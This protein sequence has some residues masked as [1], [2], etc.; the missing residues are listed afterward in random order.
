MNSLNKATPSCEQIE[1]GQKLDQPFPTI[2]FFF[3]GKK[4]EIA[5]TVVGKSHPRK[6]Y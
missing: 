1:R 3:P 2:S 6:S 4:G 5:I